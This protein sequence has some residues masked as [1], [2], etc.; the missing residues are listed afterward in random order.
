[1]WDLRSPT[2]DQTHIPCIAKQILDHWTMR[3][4]PGQL[5]KF[6]IWGNKGMVFILS[7]TIKA[8]EKIAIIIK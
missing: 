3:D 5:F 1:M 6:H 7:R 4:V 8:L 2:R